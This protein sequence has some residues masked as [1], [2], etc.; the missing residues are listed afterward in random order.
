MKQCTWHNIY[1]QY[2]VCALLDLNVSST[3]TVATVSFNPQNYTVD[4]GN[5][6]NLMIVLDETSPKNITV[7]VTTMDITAI[8]E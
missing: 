3:Y 8:G 5:P 4:E 7:V 6:A 2:G 1:K